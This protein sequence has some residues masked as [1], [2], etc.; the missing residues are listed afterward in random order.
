MKFYRQRIR[1]MEEGPERELMSFYLQQIRAA[2]GLITELDRK[3]GINGK[4][5][6]PQVVYNIK[7]NLLLRTLLYKAINQT[8]D[9][10]EKDALDFIDVIYDLVNQYSN[11]KNHE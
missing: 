7:S 2:K 8:R 6:N 3:A 5:V 1:P 11:I 4:W 9:E 10:F